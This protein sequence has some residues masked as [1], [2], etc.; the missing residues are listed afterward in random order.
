MFKL[1]PRKSYVIR[2]HLPLLDT[3]GPKYQI[4]NIL[5]YGFEIGNWK[6]EIVYGCRGLEMQV[7]TKKLFVLHY[8]IMIISHYI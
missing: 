6:L 8:K 7:A 4:L 3:S 2:T 5:E 1:K